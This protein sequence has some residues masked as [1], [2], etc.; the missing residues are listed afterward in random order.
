MQ[1]RMLVSIPVS[2]EYFDLDLSSLLQGTYIIR[3]IT[4]EKAY[5]EK[6]VKE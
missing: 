1:G 3:I 4:A 2:S 6:V 5:T